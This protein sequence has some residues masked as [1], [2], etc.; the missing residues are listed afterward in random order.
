MVFQ[1]LQEA[2]SK[3][4]ALYDQCLIL[5]VKDKEVGFNKPEKQVKGKPN[6]K[7]VCAVRWNSTKMEILTDF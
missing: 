3:S 7:W 2:S 5:P 6:I 1:T 4:N